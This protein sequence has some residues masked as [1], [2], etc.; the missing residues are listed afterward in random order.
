M[1]KLD[2]NLLLELG[3]AALPPEDKKKLLA[4]IYETLEMRVG[5]ELAKQ[6]SEAQLTEFEEFITRNDEAGALKWLETN[7]PHYKDVVAA[8]FDKLKVEIK[9][10][11][12]QILASAQ[13]AAPASQQ[14]MAAQPYYSPYPTAGN[15]Q[16]PAA[17]PTGQPQ[18]PAYSN[19]NAG[20]GSQ[21][22][23]TGYPNQYYPQ[24][25]QPPYYQVPQQQP[26]PSKGDYTTAA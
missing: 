22:Q 25:P 20:Y 6:M 1:I 12:P 24:Q 10:I 2:D 8:E 23:P 4:H 9:Q 11:A 26:D 5:V 3:L 19:P 15:V 17:P 18:T 13:T 14:P 7:F 21:Q 16:P